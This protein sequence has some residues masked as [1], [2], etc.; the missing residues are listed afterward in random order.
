MPISLFRLDCYLLDCIRR[1]ISLTVPP[2]G[3]LKSVQGN[4]HARD[5]QVQ[6]QAA[7]R[8]VRCAS[9]PCDVPGREGDLPGGSPICFKLDHHKR[10]HSLNPS[11]RGQDKPPLPC[12]TYLLP[13]SS[14]SLW[15]SLTYSTL[16]MCF[17]DMQLSLLH[18]RRAVSVSGSRVQYALQVLALSYRTPVRWYR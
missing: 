17:S 18:A 3:T 5:D 2:T 7:T 1:Y 10:L 12:T 9:I 14:G 15:A 8:D 4:H 11:D 16:A 6:Q 13:V